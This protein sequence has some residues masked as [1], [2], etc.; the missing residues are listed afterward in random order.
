MEMQQMLEGLLAK[1]NANQAKTDVTLK[2]IRAGQEH[3]KED[4]HQSRE[5]G[6]LDSRHKD[7]AKRNYGLPRSDGGLSGE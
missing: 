1:M 6:C 7:M 4:R 2:E 3:L 5:D